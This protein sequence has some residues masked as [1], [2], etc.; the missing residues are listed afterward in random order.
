MHPEVLLNQDVLKLVFCAI[1]FHVSCYRVKS[2]IS[3]S[4]SVYVY[5]PKND[6]IKDYLLFSKIN[7]NF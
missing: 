5:H 3:K 4:L 6:K 1:N 7:F 2:S